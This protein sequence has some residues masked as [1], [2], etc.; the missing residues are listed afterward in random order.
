LSKC[1]VASTCSYDELHPWGSHPL[2]D[3]LWSTA[4]LQFLHDGSEAR[5]LDKLRRIADEKLA[6]KYLRACDNP[7]SSGF[8]GQCEK[9]LRTMVGL[10]VIGKL[11]DFPALPHYIDPGLVRRLRLDE[12]TATF[13]REFLRVPIEPPPLRRAIY[14]ALRSQRFGLRPA[15]HVFSIRS[16]MPRLADMARL[17]RRVLAGPG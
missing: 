7:S 5:R 9:C 2:L 11:G 15:N 12:G 13:F 8:C 4:T 1:F 14:Y 3:P 16:R 6:M 17:I 10:H